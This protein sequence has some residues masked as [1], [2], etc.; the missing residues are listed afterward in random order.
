[1][2]G[3]IAAEL[4]GLRWEIPCGAHTTPTG[5]VAGSTQV[6]TAT[7]AG[8]TSQT[9]QVTLRFRGVAE[10]KTY[11]GGTVD[12]YWVT[13]ATENNSGYNVYKLGISSPSATFFL[14]GGPEEQRSVLI[15]YQRTIPMT[16]GSTVTLTADAQ[17]GG[18]VQN[19]DENG[20]PIVVPDIAPAPAAYDGQFIQ[21]DVVSIE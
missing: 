2:P 11:T 4:N 21:M 18:E 9:Y 13:G 12:N 17:D 10:L 20:I 5:C 16:G 3:S 1:M 15:D 19:V 14:N 7:L 6:K 8:D